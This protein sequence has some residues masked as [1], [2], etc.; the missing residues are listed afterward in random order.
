MHRLHKILF[1]SFYQKRIFVFLVTKYAIFGKY[2]CALKNY[3]QHIHNG[4][5]VTEKTRVHKRFTRIGMKAFEKVAVFA[6]RF[7]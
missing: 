4:K 6:K 5:I 3:L 2:A 7:I 1:L